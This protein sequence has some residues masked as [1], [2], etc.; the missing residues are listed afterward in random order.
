MQQSV[1]IVDT[2]A[3]VFV[4]SIL[5]TVKK[6]EESPG[7]EEM[8]VLRKRASKFAAEQKQRLKHPATNPDD[9]EADIRLR[10]A[11]ADAE[12]ELTREQFDELLTL[13][14][15]ESGVTAIKNE[16]IKRA[17]RRIG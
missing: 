2:L 14:M 1:G 8:N 17:E 7:F 12:N 5:R 3:E 16:R 13:I 11:V 9:V 4:G 6:R 15:D 10:V